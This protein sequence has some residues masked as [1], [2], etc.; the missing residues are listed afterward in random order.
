MYSANQSPTPASSSSELS[1][2]Y[3]ALKI[4]AIVMGIILVVGIIMLFASMFRHGGGSGRACDPASVTLG[5][6]D[7]LLK[8]DE[9]RDHI[10]VWLKDASGS[11]AIRHYDLC[12]GKPLRD[13]RVT[14][15]KPVAI[16]NM[17]QQPQSQP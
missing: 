11:L 15:G 3:R 12:N 1:P 4:L 17:P 16:Q 2:T 13:L 14:G 8:V 10:T 9:H 7:E 6:Q 5:A